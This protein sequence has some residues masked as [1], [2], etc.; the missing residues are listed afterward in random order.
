MV[1]LSERCLGIGFFAYFCTLKATLLIINL[2]TQ[3]SSPSHGKEK[4]N[5]QP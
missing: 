3:L 1:F 4:K 2:S 5:S